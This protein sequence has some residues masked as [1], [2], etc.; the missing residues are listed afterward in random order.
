MKRIFIAHWPDRS[1]AAAIDRTIAPWAWPLD[2]RRYAP[3]DLHV[4]LHFIGGVSGEKI[5]KIRTALRV[6]FDP[7]TLT[8][9]TPQRWPGGLA[10]LC[11]SIIPDAL[12]VLHQRLRQPLRNHDLPVSER[13]LAPHVTLA[14]RCDRIE[15]PADCQP[16]IWPV[17]GYALVL[18]TG[19]IRQRYVLL[20]SYGASRADMPHR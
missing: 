10:V 17:Q 14:R 1:T 11:P 2:C 16:I 20:E 12:I 6:P 15:M 3:R 8:L 9:D 18:S 19:D 4:T 5:D 7:F 13:A